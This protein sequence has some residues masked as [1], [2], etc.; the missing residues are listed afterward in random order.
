MKIKPISIITK[1]N[2]INEKALMKVVKLS[3][4][5][6]E[7]TLKSAN[8]KLAKAEKQSKK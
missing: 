4:Q 8:K 1:D 3:T 2:Q 5:L 6:Q 7:K